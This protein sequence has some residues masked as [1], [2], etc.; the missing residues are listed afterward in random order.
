MNRHKNFLVDVFYENGSY[1]I[2]ALFVTLVLWMTILGR[3]DRVAV[4]DVGVQVLVAQGYEVA[5]SS[6]NKIQ[7]KL[8]G[9]GTALKKFQQNGE[10]ITV[11]LDKVHAGRNVVRL[12]KTEIAVPLGVK[13]LEVSPERIEVDVRKV[14]GGEN[15]ENSNN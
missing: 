14:T 3:R 2:V 11:N 10:A 7:V 8:S 13:V 12:D 5:R 6:T 15:G 1:K 4:Q 9:P